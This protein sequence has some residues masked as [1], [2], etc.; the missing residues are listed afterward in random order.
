MA[1]IEGTW[2]PDKDEK[3]RGRG[4]EKKLDF[5]FIGSADGVLRNR[6]VDMKNDGLFI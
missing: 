3:G 6:G 4:E 1:A 5:W 2:Q